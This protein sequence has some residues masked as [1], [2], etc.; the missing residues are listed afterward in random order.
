MYTIEAIFE[1]KRELFKDLAIGKLDWN[2]DD[3]YPVIHLDFN[4][5]NYK[6]DKI[7]PLVIGE[8]LS[9]LEDKYHLKNRPE[10]FGLRFR[11][12]IQKASEIHDKGVVVLI[13]E[14]DKPILDALYCEEV[15]DKNRNILQAF[16]SVLKTMDPYIRFAMLTGISKFSKVSIFSG[17]NNLNDI[18]LSNRFNALCGISE[19]ELSN[20]FE[21]GLKRLGET[22]QMTPEEAHKEL[23]NNYD[24]YHF[25]MRERTSIILSAF[26]MRLLIKR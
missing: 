7:L 12:I 25:S 14:Y 24:G 1:G 3:R 23:K 11:Q 20:Y 21:E 4:G 5:E 17:L 22:M 2:W 6:D 19:T 13:D 16:Y 15:C 8:F 18:S 9:Q 10:T 26:L